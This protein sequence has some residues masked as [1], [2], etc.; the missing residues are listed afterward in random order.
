MTAISLL[1]LLLLA[2][3]TAA[4]KN[5][6]KESAIV[7]PK[8][9]VTISFERLN[10]RE[11]DTIKVELIVIN[12]ADYDLS[13]TS[14]EV[15]SPS[16]LKWQVIAC[17][18]QNF[19][20]P[21]ELSSGSEPLV[22]VKARSTSKCELKVTTES[23]ITVGEF[24]TF[25]IVGYQRQ[26]GNNSES[27][28]V[29]AEKTLKANLLGSES[30]AG[31]PLVLAGFI[32]PGLIF[33]IVVSLFGVSWKRG[34]LGDQMIY[35]VLI[36]LILVT[37]G[38]LLGFV[39]LNA[40][41]STGKLFRLGIGGLI[42]GAIAGGVDR[43]VREWKRNQLLTDQIN[44]GEDELVILAKLLKLPA[45]ATHASPMIELK[46][47]EKYVGSLGARTEMIRKGNSVPTALYS[48]VGSWEITQPAEGTALRKEMDSLRESGKMLQLIESAKS[49]NLIS[50]V[51]SLQTVDG[52]GNL[53]PS[54]F[55]ARI[56]RAEDV[57][58][59]TPNVQGWSSAPLG[60]K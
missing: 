3:G 6:P 47:G 9:S 17:N 8:P 44:E 41:I 28:L 4:P 26:V 58:T 11:D 38:T 60:F 21:R 32:V 5:V 15:N 20:P 7:A 24:N 37:I 23:V 34:G 2:G 12:D 18:G 51:D 52:Q 33:W 35:S 25:F 55:R 59:I 53:A 14:L 46:S 10:I 19:S 45:H 29:T 40:G 1:S 50:P 48:L 31:V 22:P 36:S 49:K 16:F 42:A 30:V 27:S 56:W 57:V 39:D 43:A 13:S 54:P